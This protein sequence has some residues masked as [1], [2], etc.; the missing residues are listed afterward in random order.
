MSMSK[1]ISVFALCG[2][3]VE[4]V[5]VAVY[6]FLNPNHIDLGLMPELVIGFALVMAGAEGDRLRNRRGGR[7][8]WLARR[9]PA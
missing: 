5:A 7:W 4:T 3:V 9:S 1:C 2:L 6:V 8:G